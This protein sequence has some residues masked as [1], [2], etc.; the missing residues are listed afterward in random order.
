[1]SFLP[2]WMVTAVLLLERGVEKAGYSFS[3]AGNFR[4]L[5]Q[6]VCIVGARQGEMWIS[7]LLPLVQSGSR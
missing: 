1:M 2:S 5:N 7:Y 4:H 3:S 6:S